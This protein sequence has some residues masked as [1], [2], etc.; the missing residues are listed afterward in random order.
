M[1]VLPR[2]LVAFAHVC[3]KFV[4]LG[5][6]LLQARAGQQ[7]QLVGD[8]R[9]DFFAQL[10]QTLPHDHRRLAAAFLIGNGQVLDGGDFFY[11]LEKRLSLVDLAG[12]DQHLH[13]LPIKRLPALGQ[14]VQSIGH[15][16]ARGRALVA[17]E[18]GT[19]Q[20][21]HLGS[22]EKRQRL[23]RL[24]EL[25]QGLQ[26]LGG[27]AHRAVDDLVVLPAGVGAPA[28]V[29]LAGA[30]AHKK[31]LVT[32]NEAEWLGGKLGFGGGH[33]GETQPCSSSPEDS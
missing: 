8:V 20:P 5:V 1:H 17:E 14:T 6:Q 30:V 21:H 4:G 10:G 15:L 19:A 28:L 12:T 33:A 2:D 18:V 23:H 16:A 26:R 7:D 22:A 27:V 24:V 3:R 32:E 29:N 11:R 9:R 25:A 31:V 13:P